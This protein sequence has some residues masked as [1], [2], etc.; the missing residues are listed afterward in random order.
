[1]KI[2]LLLAIFLVSCA[3]HKKIKEETEEEV[4]KE[5]KEDPDALKGPEKR[6]VGRIASVSKA[7]KFVL[8]QR[9]GNGTLPGNVLYQ[10]R[11]P[12]GRAASLR[13]S[14]ERV[15]DFYAADLLSGTVEVGDAV[16]AYLNPQ[17]KKENESESDQDPETI[18][19]SD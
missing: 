3:S 10:A 5:E 17:K 11:G 15:R 7:G 13:P 12:E 1:M 18:K 6:I 14:G 2:L 4:K 19:D 16:V 8:I 9:L